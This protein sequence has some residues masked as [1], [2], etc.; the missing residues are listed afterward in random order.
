MTTHAVTNVRVVLAERILDDAT[1]VVEEGRIA[2]IDP[3]GA[4]PL[5]AT[6]GHGLLLLP[7]LIDTHSD[8]L[9]KEISP[10][11]TAVFPTD[12]ALGSFERRVRSAGVTTVLHGIGYQDRP[13]I[14][15]SVTHAREMYELIEAR[16][17][18]P[19]SAVDHRVL[20]RFEARD[21]TSLDSLLDDIEAGRTGGCPEALVSFEDH[22]P[23]QGQYRDVAQFEAAVDP[24]D[25][26][27][28]M[29][30]PE[31]VAALRKEADALLE[32]R[33]RNL[34]RLIPLA[35]SGA[36]RL[37]AHDAESPEQ[38]A[39]AHDDGATIAEFPLSVEAAKEARSRGMAVV[40]GG[41]NALRG[42]SHAG[43]AS[44]RDLV[45]AD[46]C[47]VI[48]SDY[49]PSSLLASVFEMA[50]SGV[51]TLPRAVGL[52]TS[53]PAQMIGALDRGRIEVGALADLVLVDDRGP[54]PEVVA[55]R[56]G[57]DRPTRR[58]LG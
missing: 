47:D 37:L 43:N 4:R 24:T 56:R 17:Q 36:I 53:G 10:R 3:R 20:Y 26:P 44:A 28:N 18:N 54:W 8:G 55:V 5:D 31:Y 12:F 1:V 27:D 2:D 21:E 39:A 6:D 40:M 33:D 32:M 50:R 30:V 45:A 46:L 41:P 16:R 25:V 29:S 42:R 34:R 35:R 14:G 57:A 49:M 9:E 22:T 52:V 38:V 48:A 51:C 58:A 13:R 7:G 23:G 19:D 11:R 15:R